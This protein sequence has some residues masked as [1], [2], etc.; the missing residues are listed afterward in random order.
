MTEPMSEEHIRL[1]KVVRRK[2]NGSLYSTCEPTPGE[3]GCR[4]AGLTF[5][6]GKWVAPLCGMGPIAAFVKEKAARRFLHMRRLSPIW[7]D[8]ERLQ[9]ELWVGIGIASDRTK[10]KNGEPCE[11]LISD[12]PEGTAFFERILLAVCITSEEEAG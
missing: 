9:W 8:H 2:N 11:R 6:P 7:A 12:C 3:F 5:E 10:L 1:W 4:H